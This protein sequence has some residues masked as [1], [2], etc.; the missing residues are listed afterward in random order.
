MKKLILAIL[1]F[2]SLVW[3]DPF[4]VSDPQDGVEEHLFECGD[5]SVVLP[6][7]A[8]GS[9]L[10]DFANWAGGH[11]WFDCT[12]RARASYEVV[13]VLTDVTSKSVIESDPADVRIKIPKLGSNS[14]Y[15]IK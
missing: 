7:A 3:A 9:F 5:F 15:Q 1:L 2:P 6:A 8:D 14:N 12:V 13:D 11:G 10:F 4:L